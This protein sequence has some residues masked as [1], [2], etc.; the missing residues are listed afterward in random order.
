MEN[1]GNRETILPQI[2]LRGQPQPNVDLP[3][4]HAD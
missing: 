2:P 1:R 3:A 4:E